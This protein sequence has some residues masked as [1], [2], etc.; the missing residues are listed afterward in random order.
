MLDPHVRTT[1]LPVN[2]KKGW[3]SISFRVPDRHGVFKFVV[4]WRRKGYVLF[5][6][7]SHLQ[8][9]VSPSPSLSRPLDVID[10]ENFNLGRERAHRLLL[11]TLAKGTRADEPSTFPT[12]LRSDHILF[13]VNTRQNKFIHSFPFMWVIGELTFV[14]VR[15]SRAYDLT[16]PNAVAHRRRSLFQIITTPHHRFE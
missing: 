14:S 12:H 9:R 6:T 8:L 3:Y 15:L 10:L 2:G 13:G 4:D 5:F 11:R 7:S 16:C 1:V